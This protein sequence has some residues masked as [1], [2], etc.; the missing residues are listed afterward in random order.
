M[1]DENNLVNLD[2]LPSDQNVKVTKA[3]LAAAARF[4]SSRTNRSR[5]LG[6]RMAHCISKP[7][8]CNPRLAVTWHD[9]S[10][11]VSPLKGDT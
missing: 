2:N 5:L 4:F 6:L 11:S 7:A 1:S 8:D 10:R 3:D 9:T